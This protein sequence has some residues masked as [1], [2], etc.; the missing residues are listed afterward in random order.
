MDKTTNF[1]N[2]VHDETQ[3]HRTTQRS[4]GIIKL[5][6]NKLQTNLDEAAFMSRLGPERSWEPPKNLSLGENFYGHIT[7]A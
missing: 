1:K 4:K 2:T 6:F 3:K 7:W 5:K